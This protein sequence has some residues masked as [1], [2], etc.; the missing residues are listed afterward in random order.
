MKLKISLFFFVFLTAIFLV[1]GPVSA[2][3]ATPRVSQEARITTIKTRS[4]T[5]IDKRLDSLNKAAARIAGAK[6]LSDADKQT[7]S[8]E[9][10]KDIAD[11]TALRAK[12]DADTDL[13]TLKADAKTI[14]TSFRVYAVFLPQIH[15]LS[16][17]DIMGVAADN[18]S[19]I[20]TKLGTRLTELKG[21]GKDVSALETLLSDM[22]AK[23]ADAKTQ[24][25][26]VESEIV[27]LTPASYP[28]STATIKDAREKI[29]TGA[30][31]LKAAR[32]DAK[33]IRDGIHDLNKNNVKQ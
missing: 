6:K 1:H 22:N 29:K 8:T 15:L 10:Q 28:G 30:A 24:Y 16:A 33:Q 17:A 32:N 9:I 23:I 7:F 11:L 5:E 12:I 20:A 21:K 25:S 13:A 19:A 14:Y 18:L 4:D 26:A 27:G 3:T 2:Q 31:D